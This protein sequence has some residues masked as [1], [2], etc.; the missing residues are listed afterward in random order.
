MKSTGF[1]FSDLVQGHGHEY[2]L[3]RLNWLLSSGLASRATLAKRMHKLLLH[4]SPIK[5]PLA[6]TRTALITARWHVFLIPL[7]ERVKKSNAY[8]R[9]A[10]SA[11]LPL[12]EIAQQY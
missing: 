6:L 4:F 11:L 1:P 10:F 7:L 3:L 5:N 9:T 12:I 8:G 2:V